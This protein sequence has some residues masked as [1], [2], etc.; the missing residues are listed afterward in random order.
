MFYFL[1][2]S[3]PKVKTL[4]RGISYKFAL[5]KRYIT[6]SSWEIV[7]NSFLENPIL[8]ILVPL[9]IEHRVLL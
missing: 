3:D 1:Y 2:F 7:H 9:E 8:I 5:L 6:R 4:T